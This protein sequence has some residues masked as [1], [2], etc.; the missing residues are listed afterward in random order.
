MKSNRIKL[1]CL[2]VIIA[3]G[4][5]T[6]VPGDVIETNDVSSIV[7]SDTNI[8]G[9][10]STMISGTSEV[11]VDITTAVSDEPLLSEKYTPSDEEKLQIQGLLSETKKFFYDY[12]DCKEI[13]KHK[14]ENRSVTTQE[15]IDNGMLEGQAMDKIWYEVA[16]GEVMSIDALNE[17]MDQIFTEKMIDSL[18]D[19]LAN[20]YH[21]EN[22]NLYISD[23]A[24]SD[25]GLLGTDTVYINSVGKID[26]NT[27]VLY[28][29]AF[30]AGE[31]WD[32]DF[33]ITDDFTVILKKT[34]SGLK[35]D[36]CSVAAYQYIE[37]CYNSDDDI[38]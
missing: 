11:I 36:E 19:I 38:F 15:I 2:A 13:C 9:Q 27:F 26:E 32:L 31:N 1:M 5:S 23:G 29:T 22:G 28:M 4:C 8:N 18:G 30:G 16:D 20:S 12:I 35:L 6:Q 10:T 37:W 17:K 33:D 3:G 14:N 24:G 25:G 21:E 7:T 34:D